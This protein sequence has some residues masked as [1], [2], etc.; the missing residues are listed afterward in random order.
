MTVTANDDAVFEGAHTSNITITTTASAD[1]TFDNLVPSTPMVSDTFTEAS[2]TAITAHTP[3]TGFLWTE[4]Y[5][6]ST[7]GTDAT[8]DAALDVVKG[9]SNENDVGQAY[10]AGPPPTGVDQTISFT[11]SAIDTTSGTK[12]VGGVRAQAR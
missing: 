11:L 9:G 6:S 3:D 1:P 5:D 12:P 7:A 8:I 10:T 2:D 4:V